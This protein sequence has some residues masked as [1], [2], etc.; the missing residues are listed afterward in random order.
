[1]EP[2]ATVT[3]NTSVNS[4]AV[5]TTPRLGKP[6]KL[7]DTGLRFISVCESGILN[8]TFRGKPVIDGMIL[9]VYDDGR[10]NPTVGLGHFVVPEDGLGLGDLISVERAREFARRDIR[11][12]E[13]AVNRRIHIPLYQHEYDALVSIVFNAGP[14]AGMT[15]LANRMNAGDYAGMSNFILTYRASGLEWRRRLESR[16][17]AQGNYDAGH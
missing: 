11:V 6:W 9:Q 14:G 12:M 17:F 2:L 1:M 7:S 13:D 10:G 3:T 8:G 5:V 16:L 4:T 15:G